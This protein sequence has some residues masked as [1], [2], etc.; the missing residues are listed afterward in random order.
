[1]TIVTSKHLSFVALTFQVILIIYGVGCIFAMIWAGSYYTNMEVLT[2][3]L[4][5]LS[6]F[7]LCWLTSQKQL[8]SSSLFTVMIALIGLFLYTAA[9]Y[10]LWQGVVEG[11][12]YFA[13]C[14]LVSIKIKHWKKCGQSEPPPV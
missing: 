9:T 7:V 3:L 8:K 14:F 5:S 12:L 6:I 10:V 2:V 13:Y 11:F 1:M 4:A